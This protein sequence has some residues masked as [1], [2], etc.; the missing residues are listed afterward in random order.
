MGLGRNVVLLHRAVPSGGQLPPRPPQ[1][2]DKVT[3]TL[4]EVSPLPLSNKRKYIST[5]PLLKNARYGAVTYTNRIHFN[6]FRTS[7]DTIRRWA[8]SAKPHQ[9]ENALER[10]SSSW[11]RCENGS[12]HTKTLSVFGVTK[13]EAKW[14]RISVDITLAMIKLLTK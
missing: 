13:N 2:F 12:V 11:K 7:V 5:A 8:F 4:L 10:A 14:K 9:C 6:A 3:I 1:R